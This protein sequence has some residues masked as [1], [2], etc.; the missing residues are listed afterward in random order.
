MN[1][2]RQVR[3]LSRAECLELLATGE[4]GRVALCSGASSA[5][6]VLPVSYALEDGC[7]VFR[8]GPGVKLDAADEGVAVAFEVD[9]FNADL[10]IG[11]SVLVTGV[12]RRLTAAQAESVHIDPWL[13][14][15]R[16]GGFVRIEPTVVSGRRV[17]PVRA[18]GHG[19]RVP[20]EASR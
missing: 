6:V 16:D 14:S 10:R 20:V 2:R 5:P 18:G 19:S 13:D 3:L 4:I 9:D 8:S 7:I 11:W 15:G 1:A 12:A 17:V